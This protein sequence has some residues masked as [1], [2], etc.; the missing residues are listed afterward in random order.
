[1]LQTLSHTVY[2][3]FQ[4]F[5]FSHNILV[6]AAG[7]S[8]GVATKDVIERVLNSIISP[9]SRMFTRLGQSHTVF[10]SSFLRVPSEVI[11]T[12]LVWIMTITFTFF[13]LE[14]FLN[15]YVFG[16]K[17]TLDENAEKTFMKA[18]EA[19]A[20]AKTHLSIFT[21]EE[22]FVDHGYFLYNAD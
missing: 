8:I 21:K 16:L 1:M 3:D 4:K 6:S 7:F 5:I 12:V 22:P 20:D 19:A 17:T 18:K 13:I 10:S 9:L 11:W 14:Y 2:T 15:R